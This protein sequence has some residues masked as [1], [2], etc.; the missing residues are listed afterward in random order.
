M[1]NGIYRRDD[2]VGTGGMASVYE[3]WDEKLDR[4]V[5]I[6]EL[7]PRYRDDAQIRALFLREGRKMAQLH[8]PNVISIFAIEEEREQPWLIMEFADG[9]TLLGKIESGATPPAEARKI[10]QGLLEGLAEIHKSGLV[11]RDLK[12]EN[13]LCSKDV[14]KIGDFGI[15]KTASGDETARFVTSKYVAPEAVMA[16]DRVGPAADIYSLGLTVFELLLGDREYHRATRKAM[17]RAIGIEEEAGGEF[18]W[19]RWYQSQEALPAPH[20]ISPAIP[21]DLSRIVHRMIAKDPGQ[22]YQTCEEVLDDL[23]ETAASGNEEDE[24]TQ[25]I[26]IVPKKRN[27]T[28]ILSRTAI[29]CL[30]LLLLGI[31]VL[32]MIPTRTPIAVSSEPAEAEVYVGDQNIGTTPFERKIRAGHELVFRKQGYA[33]TMV[34]IEEDTTA[35]APVLELLEVVLGLRTTPPG[36]AV[37]REAEMLGRTPLDGLR[38]APGTRLSLERPGFKAAK[39]EVTAEDEEHEIEL[40]PA[41]RGMA[42]AMR[43]AQAV[44]PA[45]EVKL[46]VAGATSEAEAPWVRLALAAEVRFLLRS[47][48]A[49]AVQLLYVSGDGTIVV[50]YPNLRQRGV[51]VAAGQTIELARELQMVTQP[52][53]GQDVAIAVV[54]NTPIQFPEIPGRQEMGRGLTAY[55]DQ[56]LNTGNPANELVDWLIATLGTQVGRV[57]VATIEIEVTS[58]SP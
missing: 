43:L 31:V 19:I 58:S 28:K 52:P 20:D 22:R 33:E 27:W 24:D 23:R 46:E 25:S 51:P 17:C 14:Y 3:G 54:S 48:S 45:W 16:P 56:S 50:V 53:L 41:T 44:E 38:V 15:A 2:L 26:P 4:K 36:A 39:L 5:A 21:Q 30:G 40:E 42:Y 8:N 10:L 11:H 7:S 12:P 49:G 55:P 34:K 1:S 47:E 35:V 9:G 29:G 18:P 32:L 37:L 57:T 13:I 6:K